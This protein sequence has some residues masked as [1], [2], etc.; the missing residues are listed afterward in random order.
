MMIVS[1][2]SI[3]RKRSFIGFATFRFIAKNHFF[4]QTQALNM[5]IH[6][7]SFDSGKSASIKQAFNH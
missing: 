7:L 3:S 2:I 4:E 5:K 1:K 6:L